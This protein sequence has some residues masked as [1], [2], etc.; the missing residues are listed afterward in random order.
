MIV[1]VSAG[2]GHL[3]GMWRLR[4]WFVYTWLCLALRDLVDNV[5]S[6]YFPIKSPLHSL[7]PK[8]TKLGYITGAIAAFIF[9]SQV[10]THMTKT[11]WFVVQPIKLTT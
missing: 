6:R 4:L 7:S 10:A 3:S 8:A 2:H 1:I 9:Y 11:W 5:F